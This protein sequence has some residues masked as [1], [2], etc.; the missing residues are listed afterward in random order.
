MARFGT[1]LGAAVAL[2][3]VDLAADRV[4]GGHSVGEGG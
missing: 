4:D 1:A 2:L 3:F